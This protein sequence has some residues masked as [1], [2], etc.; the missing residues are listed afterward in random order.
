MAAMTDDSLTLNADVAALSGAPRVSL[1]DVASGSGDWA[2]EVA[3]FW[4]DQG[5]AG[6]PATGP[7]GVDTENLALIPRDFRGITLSD[8]EGADIGSVA[9]LVVDQSTGVIMHAVFNGGEM[10]GNRSFVVP[11]THLS[12]LGNVGTQ[13]GSF[14]FNFPN[15]ALQNAPSL[16]SLENLALDPETINMLMQFWNAMQNQQ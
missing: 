11:M 3:S 9:D 12:W 14:Q 1:T 16:E 6:I 15:D 10:F 7:A 5:V 4:T 8:Q 2:G 13:L